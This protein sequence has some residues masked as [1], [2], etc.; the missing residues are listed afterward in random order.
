MYEY[1]EI[2][3][4]GGDHVA[5]F[6]VSHGGPQQGH[7]GQWH[8]SCGPHHQNRGYGTQGQPQY[9]Q[10]PQESGVVPRQAPQQASR[11]VDEQHQTP[12]PQNPPA[13]AAAAAAAASGEGSSDGTVPPTYA[14]AVKGD[15]KVQTQ[16]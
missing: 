11:P 3:Q 12:Q 6:F 15:F 5:Y 7:R 13:A 9:Q 2:P 16:E 1:A 4:D 8:T 14:E 10:P